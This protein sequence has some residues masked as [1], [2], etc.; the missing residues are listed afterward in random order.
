MQCAPYNLKENSI[1]NNQ[2]NVPSSSK[3]TILIDGEKC[4]MQTNSKEPEIQF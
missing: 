2:I 1:T 4:N 3:E